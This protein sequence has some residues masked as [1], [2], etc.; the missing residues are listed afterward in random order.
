MIIIPHIRCMNTVFSRFIC[1]QPTV[2]YYLLPQC[3]ASTVPT[4]Q[5][6]SKV[7]LVTPMYSKVLLV[8]QMYS[9]VLLVTAVQ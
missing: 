6:Y 8:T 5:M 3:T 4:T 7:L 2:R 9:K 1:Y